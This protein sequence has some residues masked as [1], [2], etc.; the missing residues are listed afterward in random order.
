MWK[1]AT[2]TMQCAPDPHC[3]RWSHPRTTKAEGLPKLIEE[4]RAVLDPL[5]NEYEIIIVDDGSK[6]DTLD[7]LVDLQ[8]ADRRVKWVGLS[9]NFGHQAAL[10]AGLERARGDVVISMDADLQHPP[11][12]LPTLMQRW[13]EGSDV[14]YT[15][16]RSG[17]GAFS[18]GRRVL[19]WGRVFHPSR[20]LRD[21]SAFRTVRLSPLGPC[22][23]GRPPGHS[24]A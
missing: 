5:A 7:V 13:R 19:M 3:C 22:G 1:D 10:L 21:E 11:A 15:V 6:D 23:G 4:L 16:K 9:R 18:P 8:R 12:L 2:G 24:R 20:R 17:S 14:V